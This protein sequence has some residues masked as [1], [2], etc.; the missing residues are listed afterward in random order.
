[1]ATAFWILLAIVQSQNMRLPADARDGSL[2]HLRPRV[3]RIARAIADGYERSITFRKLVDEVHSA[4]AIVYIEAGRCKPMSLTTVNGCLAPRATTGTVRY[5]QMVVDLSRSNDR[6]IALIG[7]ELQ[8]VH[9]LISVPAASGGR[10]EAP[11]GK[12]EQSAAR[13]YETEQA[14]AVTAAILKELRTIGPRATSVTVK[15]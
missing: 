5:F 12:I 2:G 8:H 15:K 13:T 4:G 9:E 11:A 14:R 6:L 1:M 7:H 10:V 3:D